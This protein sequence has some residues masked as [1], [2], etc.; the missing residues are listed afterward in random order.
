MSSLTPET[1]TAPRYITIHG[2]RMHYMDEGT[3]KTI[4]F[5]HGIPEWSAVY[6][7]IVAQLSDRYRCIVPDHLGFGLS[8]RDSRIALTPLAHAQRLVCL[9]K[10]LDLTD[11]HLV[12]HDL[13]GPI[14][15]RTAVEVPERISSVTLTN[16]FCWDLK[17]SSAAR[18]LSLMD[19][20]IGRWLYLDKGFSV[21][22]MAANAFAHRGVYHRYQDTFLQVHQTPDDRYANYILM[23]EMLRSGKFYSETL[24]KFHKLHLRGQIVWGMRDTFFSAKE[25]LTRW[26][27]EVPGY[28]VTELRTSGHFPQ[29]EVPVEYARAISTFAS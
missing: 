21:K 6:Q 4:L 29:L 14:G 24:T 15:L 9:I 17:G 26:Q 2:K 16:T 3:G 19:G 12:V 20:R 5:V 25:Y 10:E 8:E 1:P 11:I 7:P 22:V 28:K 23:M 13:G 27:K 18:G